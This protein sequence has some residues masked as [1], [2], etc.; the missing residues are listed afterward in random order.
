VKAYRALGIDERQALALA[1]QV[2]HQYY[3]PQQWQVYDDTRAQL[4]LLSRHGWTHVVLSN[5]GPELPQLIEALALHPFI[6]KVFTSALT[7]YEKPHP[8]A[9]E[10]VLEELRPFDAAW[11][12]G[13][14]F[15]ADIQGAMRVGLSAILVRNHHADAVHCC[16]SLQDVVAIVG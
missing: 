1:N 8:Q 16:V 15:A 2:R 5:H 9:F 10:C 4:D 6:T 7:G 3:Q 14:N 13:D 12:I 11:M